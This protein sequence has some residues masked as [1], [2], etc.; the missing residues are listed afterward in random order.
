[1]MR[2][3]VAEKHEEAQS[4]SGSRVSPAISQQSLEQ[5][6]IVDENNTDEAKSSASGCHDD[7][8]AASR[9]QS[10]ERESC[11][12][13]EDDQS[14]DEKRSKMK[15]SRNDDEVTK[16]KQRVTKPY[17]RSFGASG[18]GLPGQW[19][20]EVNLASQ[21]PLSS[22][23]HYYPPRTSYS[24]KTAPMTSSS[25]SLGNL[26]PQDMSS[27]LGLAD[28]Q[29]ESQNQ[30]KEM[31][32]EFA[33]NVL[34]FQS[35]NETYDLIRRFTD[36]RGYPSK[37]T[38]NR[39][40]VQMNN[41]QGFPIIDGQGK[42]SSS[43]PLHR[44]V[45]LPQVP[46]SG[47][48]SAV[49]KRTLNSTKPKPY[50]C[51]I[52]KSKFTRYHNLKQHVKLHSGVKPYSCKICNKSFTRNYTLK[53][54]N[55]KHAES[56]ALLRCDVCQKFFQDQSSFQQH[57]ESSHHLQKSDE[58]V[59]QMSM[60]NQIKMEMAGDEESLKYKPNRKVRYGLDSPGGSSGDGM[61][62]GSSPEEVLGYQAEEI[63]EP[64]DLSISKESNEKPVQAED[65]KEENPDSL[66]TSV[67]NQ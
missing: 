66:E 6:H 56:A 49:R 42:G 11:K 14:L 30:K 8:E 15:R 2:Q 18:V 48:Y 51:Q 9:L 63:E 17:A 53:L 5:A 34:N 32:N 43:Q 25:S 4:L 27:I 33:N 44:E 26:A 31:A 37:P 45:E 3:Y 38:A 60:F 40:W 59:K 1:M 61:M 28:S 36:N 46:A 12:K 24:A 23:H 65:K 7:T 55:K 29:S 50:Q 62:N 47:V 19:R 39:P 58:N 52:C 67:S 41:S 64:T 20:S 10:A 35:F 54:H 16:R 57:I 22:F 13:T 21:S